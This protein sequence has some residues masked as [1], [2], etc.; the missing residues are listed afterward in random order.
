MSN[1][2]MGNQ[3]G[4]L[5]Q[6]LSEAKT[7]ALPSEAQHWYTKQGE[8]CY[9][10]PRADGKGMRSATLADARKL[11]L[12]PS[13]TMILQCAAKPGLEAWKARQILEAALTL[14]KLPNETL[15]DYATRV[16]EDSKQQGKK[17]AEKGT[18]LHA[19]IEDYIRGQQ[20]LLWQSHCEKLTNVLDQYGINILQG[21]PEHS[22]ASPL[23]YGGKTD[24]VQNLFICDFKT[25]EFVKGVKQLAWP[26]MLWQLAAYDK[27]I[28]GPTKRRL[29]NVFIG[30]KDCEIRIHEWT[31]EDYDRGWLAFKALLDFWQITKNY[32]GQNK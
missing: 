27:G 10:V 4:V 29:L 6:G 15:D 9:E 26:E 23:G 16:I 28:G 25:K 24:F 5:R 8:P 11:N 12:V 3:A 31:T 14:P 17:A 2:N 32:N 7:K 20:S 18:E 19:A 30:I 22:F 21:E 13:V 1:G